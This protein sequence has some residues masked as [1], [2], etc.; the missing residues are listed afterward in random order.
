MIKKK[1]NNT[2]IVF[3]ILMVSSL[4]SGMMIDVIY[5]SGNNGTT[6]DGPE[7]NVTFGGIEKDDGFAL[8]QTNDG[9]YIIAGETGSFSPG[10]YSD[11]YLL[12]TDSTGSLVWEKTY[13]GNQ[14]DEFNSIK[15][16]PG[17]GY[18]VGGQTVSYS[19]GDFDSWLVKID[20]NG[21]EEWNN[22]YGDVKA[23]YL[24]NVEPTSDGGYIF[25]GW[26]W[27]WW[28]EGGSDIWL[29]KT[30]SNGVKSWQKTFGGYAGDYGY[31]VQQ[32]SDGGY[33]ITGFS[34]S[35][36]AYNGDLW[37]IKTNSYG[38]KEWDKFIG[39]ASSDWGCSVNQT[40]DG[41][42]IISG[43]TSSYGSGGQDIFLVKT[44][45]SGNEQWN[46]TFGGTGHDYSYSVKQTSDGGYVLSGYTNSFGAGGNDIWL[47]KTDSTGKE[48]LNSTYGGI[49]DDELYYTD[50]MVLSNNGKFVLVGSTGSFGLGKE[51]VWLLKV[52]GL[53]GNDQS[54][55]G[56]D[57]G[58]D[59][60]VVKISDG[61]SINVY[62]RTGSTNEYTFTISTLMGEGGLFST[63]AS[64]SY[65]ITS[66][67]TY[68]KV[69]CWRPEDSDR[70]HNLVAVRLNGVSGYSEGLWA[71]N[72]VEYSLG[73]DGDEDFNNNCLGNDMSTWTQLGDVYSSITLSFSVDQIIKG[74]VSYW[75]FDE[76]SGNTAY[77]SSVNSND[78]IIYGA[79][80]VDGVSGKSLSFDGID[81]YV[82]FGSNSMNNLP[83]LT[84]SCW[85]NYNT[86][87]GTG[88]PSAGE[89]NNNCIIRKQTGTGNN[90]NY[91]V[92]LSDKKICFL[93]CD[94]VSKVYKLKSNT[95]LNPDKWYHI[96]VTR[97]GDIAKVFINGVLDN[98]GSYDFVPVSNPNPLNVA[99]GDGEYYSS[100]HFDGLIDEVKIYNKAL[101]SSEI[102]SD[103]N[104]NKPSE[105]EIPPSSIKIEPLFIVN[106]VEKGGELFL[107]YR[108]T[109]NNKPVND[110]TL[111]F[112]PNPSGSDTTAVSGE[113]GDGIAV[114]SYS[115]SSVNYGSNSFKIADASYK[116]SNIDYSV[117]ENPVSVDVIDRVCSTSV[118]V[119]AS[120]GGELKGVHLEGGLSAELGLLGNTD[121]VSMISLK[122]EGRIGA[123]VKSSFGLKVNQIDFQPMQIKAVIGGFFGGEA[124]FDDLSDQKER[125]VATLLVTRVALTYM[126][127]TPYFQPIFPVL[128][129][130]IWEI[131]VDL[132][133]RLGDTSYLE[134]GI[135]ASLAGNLGLSLNLSYKEDTTKGKII[136]KFDLSNFSVYLK[137]KIDAKLSMKYYMDGKVGVKAWAYPYITGNYQSFLGGGN[138]NNNVYIS[139]ERIYPSL[140]AVGSDFM[141]PEK[142]IIRLGGKAVAS[143]ID[144]TK[145]KKD[146]FNF[147]APL[148]NYIKDI[149]GSEEVYYLLEYV[150]DLTDAN[151]M[152]YQYLMS[153]AR[154]ADGFSF[155]LLE[156][157]ARVLTHDVTA[158]YKYYIFDKS[159]FKVDIDLGA[160]IAGVDLSV[161]LFENVGREY[162]SGYV[163]DGNYFRTIKYT[164]TPSKID[165]P[166]F[167]I[168]NFDVDFILNK[169]VFVPL[170][171]LK[172]SIG[173]GINNF[174]SNTEDKIT[175]FGED[176][177]NRIN[178]FYEGTKS[179]FDNFCQDPIGFMGFCPINIT[180]INHEGLMIGYLDDEFVNEIDGAY[181]YFD[182]IDACY[183]YLPPGAYII[184]IE[185]EDTG[186][187]DCKLVKYTDQ[188][189]TVVSINNVDIN[190]NSEDTFIPKRYG[191]DYGSNELKEYDLRV[192]RISKNDEK[193][194]LL[195]NMAI[196]N[197]SS[198]KY[199]VETDDDQTDS[200]SGFVSYAVDFDDD[201]KIDSF[202]DLNNGMTQNEINDLIEKEK[203]GDVKA[204]SSS[205]PG[206]ELL[207]VIFVLLV[208]VLFKRKR[209]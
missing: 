11:A 114:V 97:N 74:L 138:L 107:Y 6:S 197:G 27:S 139:I 43:F 48:Q 142:I 123:G 68:L 178:D 58:E 89:L 187:Y 147:Y 80:Y 17:G 32:T 207:L 36:D 150:C 132:G 144:T 87:M 191:F 51:D 29:V 185:G 10:G 21:N 37:L 106:S 102:E 78:G 12:K 81:D 50:S 208:I 4:L 129:A 156:S 200:G 105:E 40:T 155:G 72:I 18:I 55:S 121:D 69:E 61:T 1:I 101:S 20:E 96:T 205:S 86:N 160:V 135:F 9:G 151:A 189:T 166:K 163:V 71:T 53:E 196:D 92:T 22:T 141:N 104:D 113:I 77:D 62:E 100:R 169:L 203:E 44:D 157:L 34:E 24:F 202:I 2:I 45:S 164:N 108:V 176:T 209:N 171:N 31:S 186:E 161:E 174:V 181:Y 112:S 67:G 47:I 25:T 118:G 109:E 125:E 19:K 119:S 14:R 111:N 94:G 154:G 63:G 152:K 128:L 131:D 180:I 73:S 16:I 54:D 30:N 116:G 137:Y 23:D 65:K 188:S 146:L 41:G 82:D 5:S 75:N 175:K 28:S 148:E 117:T 198:H 199:S 177:K 60:Q 140:S 172:N 193:T 35:N 120:V 91:A 70:G 15:K 93:F 8:I 64:E 170:N 98:S 159:D 90:R 158:E 134:G 84:I 85:I 149:S 173:Q 183:Y 52:T 206:F 133:S 182:D 49:Y 115:L 110:V 162:E 103:Y 122:T 95:E 136:R 168:N 38:T 13:G 99:W 145:I 126:M 153:S 57:N 59:S 167:F 204:T 201:G 165:I 192:D 42:Y 124:V 179:S 33:I 184:I 3:L 56:D 66:D 7:I 143:K 194:F 127:T 46:K 88:T 76:G 26:T 79:T 130:A 83:Q 190:E 39:G 195:N